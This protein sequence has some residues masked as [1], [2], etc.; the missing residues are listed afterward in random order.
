MM[1]NQTVV[2]LV[3][4]LCRQA[5]DFRDTGGEIVFG[6]LK[7]SI[8]VKK[9]VA[10]ERKKLL[11]G[12]HL[13]CRQWQYGQDHLNQRNDDQVIKDMLERRF[14]FLYQIAKKRK[15]HVLE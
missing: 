11:Q 3:L 10:E 4:F 14:I 15:L 12:V 1:K 8:S 6:K 13:A 5:Y 7:E 2:G 9:Q